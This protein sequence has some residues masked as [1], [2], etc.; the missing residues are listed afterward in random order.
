MSQRYSQL[1]SLRA[2]CDRHAL[3]AGVHLSDMVTEVPRVAV[4][5]FGIFS[6]AVTT[7]DL[8][9]AD[10]ERAFDRPLVFV[11]LVSTRHVVDSGQSWL[12][13]TSKGERGVCR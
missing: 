9:S 12:L 1:R 3:R 6:L 8:A 13:K 7:E 10:V 4:Y 5:H 2:H 11:S